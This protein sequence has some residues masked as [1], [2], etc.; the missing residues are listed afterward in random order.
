MV[1]TFRTLSVTF[2]ISLLLTFTIELVARGSA[3]GALAFFFEPYRPSWTTVVIFC[4]LFLGLDAL[5]G[6]AHQSLLVVA[7]VFMVLA[8]AGHQK[9]YY[10]GDPLYPTDFLY[11]WQIV[12]LLPLLIADRPWTA[13]GM[14][15]SVIFVIGALLYAW[16]LWRRKFPRLTARNRILRLAVALPALA[17]VASIMDYATFSWTRDRLQIFPIMWDQ[18]E[19]YAHN[20]FALAFAMNVPMAKVSAPEGYSPEAIAD[21]PKPAAGTVMPLDRPDIIVVMS[22]SFWDPRRLPGTTVEPDPLKNVRAI[23]SGHMFSPEFGGMTANV[24]FEALTGFSNAFLPYGSIPYQQ[25][26]RKTLPS[27][28]TFLKDQGYDTLA[29]HPFEGWFWNRKPVYEAF[30]FDRFLSI[31]NLPPMKKRGPLV[32][33]A[34]LTD[35]II[36]EAD[37]ETNPFFIFAVSLQSH[38]PYEPNR[39]ASTTH[40]V[41]TIGGPWARGSILT[42]SEGVADADKGLQDLI[43]WASRRARPTVIAFF[44]DHLPPLGPAYVSTGFLAEPVPPRKEAPEKMALH[45]ETPLVI[46]SNRSG[47]TETGTISPAFIPLEILKSAGIQHPY[48]TDFLGKVRGQYPVVERNMLIDGNGKGTPDWSREK[49][50]A[51]LIRDYRFLQYDMMFGDHHGAPTYFPETL[52]KPPGRDPRDRIIGFDASVPAMANG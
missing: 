36:R 51:P 7:P 10:L 41:R 27:M 18:K 42:Y 32:S 21:A 6:R 34:A 43:D 9:A 1:R 31:E 30:G 16:R 28:A 45:R 5:F 20:G 8:F 14:V 48:Y 13:V 22:E 29:I 23:Q 15:A 52:P 49:S 44:G 46:W 33:D 38:G 17:F 50:V 24:E 2:L 47:S 19:N 4:L 25:Y 3:G 37:A 11:A 12:E 40:T 26:V 39:Y 35:E